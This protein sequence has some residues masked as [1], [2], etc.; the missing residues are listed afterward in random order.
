[1]EGGSGG[2]TL[3]RVG[4]GVL[5]LKKQPLGRKTTQSQSAQNF[6]HE[7]RCVEDKPQVRIAGGRRHCT[8]GLA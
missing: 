2:V 3:L 5:V 6:Q 7:G 8:N 1:M 4:G